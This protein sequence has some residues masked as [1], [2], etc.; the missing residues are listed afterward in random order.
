MTDHDQLFKHL[1]QSLFGEFL[2]AFVPELRRDLDTE[3]IKFLDKE[4][5]RA[6]GQHRQTRLV[7]LVARVRFKGRR[8]SSWCISSTKVG[9]RPTPGGACSFTQRG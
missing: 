8:V 2:A 9:G 6:R 5:I 7:D 1:L 3:S 4:L